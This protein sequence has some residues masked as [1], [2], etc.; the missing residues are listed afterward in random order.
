MKTVINVKTDKALKDKAQKTAKKL[1]LPLG[2]VINNYLRHFVE[3]SQV[4][5]SVPEIPNKRTVAILRQTSKDYREG[6]NIAGPFSTGEE[7]DAYLNS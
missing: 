7:M 1:G 4:I 3:E 2:T 5:F 6:K